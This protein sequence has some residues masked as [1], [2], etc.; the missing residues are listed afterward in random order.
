MLLDVLVIYSSN[1]IGIL[2][3]I[4]TTSL[5]NNLENNYDVK[6]IQLAFKVDSFKFLSPLIP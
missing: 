5:I 4:Q 2:N 6:S 1:K 3:I